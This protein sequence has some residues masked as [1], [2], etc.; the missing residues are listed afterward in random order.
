MNRKQYDRQRYL[1]NREQRLEYQ[2]EYYKKPEN[3]LRNKLFQRK[4]YQ[5]IKDNGVW[6]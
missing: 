1:K 3:K 6:P 2:K 5:E 4:R